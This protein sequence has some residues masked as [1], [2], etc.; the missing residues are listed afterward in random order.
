[1][2][3]SKKGL[4]KIQV[5]GNAYF[6]KFQEKIYVYKEEAKNHPLIVDV[7][8]YDAWLFIQDKSNKPPD[9]EPKTIT[10]QFLRDAIVFAVKNGWE[11]RKLAIEYREGAFIPKD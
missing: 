8:W 3:I 10:P 5:E 1:M 7:G 6:W 2:A 9:F 4:R 11:N